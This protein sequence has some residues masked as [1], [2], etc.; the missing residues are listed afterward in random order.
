MAWINTKASPFG[1]LIAQRDFQKLDRLFFRTL[2]QST[3]LLAAGAALLLLAL[4]GVTLFFP[5]LA[6]RVLPL[7]IFAL[8][9]ATIVCNHFVFSEALYLRA[10]KREPFLP[11]GI[12]VAVLTTCSTLLLGKYWGAPGVTL[13]YFFINGVFGLSFGTYIFITKRRQWHKGPAIEETI[14]L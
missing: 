7:S 4:G 1:I 6:G 13:G 5:R 8:L 12:S 14:S 9:L 11:L 2:L 10:H 3:F